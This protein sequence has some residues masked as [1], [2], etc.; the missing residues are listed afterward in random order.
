MKTLVEIFNTGF[1]TVTVILEANCLTIKL[2][3]AKS[4]SKNFLEYRKWFRPDIKNES[5]IESKISLSVLTSIIRDLI[6]RNELIV[7]R[8]PLYHIPPGIY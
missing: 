6:H 7:Q 4:S 8:L 2:W 1:L 3:P 5:T